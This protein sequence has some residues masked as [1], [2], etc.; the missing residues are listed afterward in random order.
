MDCHGSRQSDLTWTAS[1]KGLFA[2]PLIWSALPACIAGEVQ[3]AL[4][5]QHLQS[6]GSLCM[7]IYTSMHAHV[8]IDTH[9][10]HM[11][12]KRKGHLR[13]DATTPEESHECQELRISYFALSK[14]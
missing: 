12:V 10:L 7:S 9:T 5:V 8:H 4:Q 3:I 11:Y 14:R 1:Q 13:T 2:E 6:T